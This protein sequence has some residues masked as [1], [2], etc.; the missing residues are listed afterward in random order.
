MNKISENFLGKRISESCKCYWVNTI[1][2]CLFD[3]HCI[4]VYLI[5]TQSVC[6]LK[7]F[8]STYHVSAIHLFISF[9]KSICQV[10]KSI[11]LSVIYQLTYINVFVHISTSWDPRKHTWLW[12]TFSI[13]F[14]I[15]DDVISNIYPSQHG[16]LLQQIVCDFQTVA[17]FFHFGTV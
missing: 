8:S 5:V 10:L 14:K 9:C 6:L 7:C 11:Q 17:I 12:R 15:T 1:S 13:T 16:A 4:A 3:N 2:I